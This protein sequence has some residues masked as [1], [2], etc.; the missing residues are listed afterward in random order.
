MILF[1]CH[2]Y[3]TSNGIHILLLHFLQYR[4]FLPSSILYPTRAGL[5]QDPQIIIVLEASKKRGNETISPFS[6]CFF[7]L[8]CF[9]I[10]L[11]PSTRILL[12]TGSTL[13]TFPSFPLSLP[14]I[15][16]TVSFLCI[17]I[18]HTTK[19]AKLSQYDVY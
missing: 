6:P 10:K 12:D 7:D 16:L 9:F 11:I 4:I 5:E 17:F 3:C 19:T 18:P 1:I 8:R 14:A 2:N 13:K 15:I